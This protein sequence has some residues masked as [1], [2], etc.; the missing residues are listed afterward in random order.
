MTK[1]II[2]VLLSLLLIATLTVGCG[3]DANTSNNDNQDKVK[4]QKQEDTQDL[5][6]ETSYY[7]VTIKNYNSQGEE[8]QITFTKRPDKIIT[9]N[10][11][12]TELLLTLGLEDIMVGT[13]YLDNPI[14][15]KLKE[16][17]EKIPVLSNRYPSKEV[18]IAKQPN[19]IFGWSSA[20]MDKNIGSVESWN[21]K[22]V[23]T[24]IQRNS[25]VAD[26]RSIENVYKDIDDIGKIF[27]IK[28]KADKLIN[29]MKERISNIQ[30]KIKDEEPVKV[31]ALEEA[32]D[33]KY[34]VYG[35][36]SL[37]NDMIEK[38]GGINLAE[39]SGTYSIENIVAKNPDAI[40]LIHY[41]EQEKDNDSIKGLKN[42]SVLNNVNAIKNDKI[43]FTPLAET[44]AGGIRTI[45]GIERFAKEFYP[46]L[47][48]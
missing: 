27:N 34:R 21:K 4:Q 48:K 24:F 47:F 5:T 38:A 43:I 40:I 29:S 22:G 25:G 6:K 1:R 42:N 32:G 36:T 13:S 9:T 12:P 39:K 23:Y 44:Y 46:E 10:Q 28:D 18:V 11:P 2:T 19:L 15:P 37:I 26:E 41:L 33:N 8:Y 45:K 3:S 35:K 20:F 16:K 17:Y 7:P 14:L 30:D 31:L